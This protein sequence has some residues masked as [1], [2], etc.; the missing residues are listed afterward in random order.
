TAANDP[1]RACPFGGSPAAYTQAFGQQ[2]AFAS[3]ANPALQAGTG[4]IGTSTGDPL[5]ATFA[6]IFNGGYSYV[7]WNDQFQGSPIANRGAPW[8]HSKGILAWNDNGDGLVIQ[9]ST[10]GWPGSGSARAPRQGDGNTLGCTTGNNVMFS[11][12]FF[13]LRLSPLDVQQV[14]DGL[15]NASVVTD[16]TVPQLAS[17]GGPQPIASRAQTLGRLST[18]TAIVSRTLSS[19]VRLIAKPSALQVPPWQMVSAMLGASGASSG[20]ALRT[21]N[22]WAAPTIPSTTQAG[23]PGCWGIAQHPG[24]VAIATSGVWSG[25]AI[26]LWGGHAPNGNHA[27]IGVSVGGAPYY[28]ILGD[29]NQQGSLAPASRPCQSSQNGRGGLFFVVDNQP[30]HDSVAALIAGNTA[31]L[32]PRRSAPAPQ[33]AAR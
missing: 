29:L 5:G 32:L 6:Q 11:Q 24:P 21:A 2:Y 10:P 30:L 25:R 31:S 19:G 26:G 7:V 18:S 20:P 17:I 8:G 28:T 9:V 13:A 15:A 12:H 33:Y 16:V 4:L 3:S 1:A 22:W 27:K 23:D 14:L